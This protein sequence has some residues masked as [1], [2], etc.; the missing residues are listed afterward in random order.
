M[1][2]T[3]KEQKALIDFAN[4]FSIRHTQGWQNYTQNVSRPHAV[5]FD[6]ENEQQYQ[7]V[8]D[9]VAKLNTKKEPVERIT[10]RVANGG[11]EDLGEY[12]KYTGSFSITDCAAGDVIVRLSGK[13]FRKIELIDE[14]KKIVRVGA[15]VLAGELDETLYKKFSLTTP[16]SSYIYWSTF[17][18]GLTA[19]GGHGTG[20]NQPSIPGLIVSMKLIRPDGA[21]V[22]ISGTKKTIKLR[23]GTRISIDEKQKRII[24]PDGRDELTEVTVD[25]FKALQEEFETIRGAH[26]GLFGTVLEADIQC[27]NAK[28]LECIMKPTNLAG[29]KQLVSDG[30]YIKN[31]Y[32]TVW[33]IP[34]YRG[35]NKE[36]AP[37]CKSNLVVMTWNPVP[38]ETLDSNNH[39]QWTI[40]QEKIE[41]GLNDL[42]DLPGLLAS[43][44]HLIPIFM[45]YFS[46]QIEVRCKD[47]RVIAPWYEIA[48]RQIFPRNI[49]DGDILF[50]TKDANNGEEII[51]LFNYLVDTLQD[52]AD[53]GLYPVIYEIFLRYFLGSNG[54]LSMSFHGE[55]EH[56]A[57]I[58]FTS[59]RKI[60][61]LEQ[62]N[63]E[64]IKHLINEF[65]GRPHWGKSVP[66][67]IDYTKIYG[68]KFAIFMRVL[69]KWYEDCG[70]KLEESFLLNDFLAS[71]LKLETAKSLSLAE[72]V[73]ERP[74]RANNWEP[75]YQ[76]AEELLKRLKQKDENFDHNKHA[77]KFEQRLM[78]VIE[79]EKTRVTQNIQTLFTQPV[80]PPE[81]SPVERQKGRRCCVIV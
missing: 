27:I 66:L 44:P 35:K 2:L 51:A 18:S 1:P 20:G 37:D 72:Q 80:Q 31:E 76:T 55:N 68:D 73:N 79:R 28:K 67:D 11:R 7:A 69:K 6:V 45:R 23:G 12:S 65:G 21:K 64:V 19:N 42:F 74:M 16:T 14:A 53:R 9:F 49:S 77:K 29:F 40:L 78:A 25:E 57:G 39:K 59:A 63:E 32:V 34:T 54:G 58:D 8:Q 56:T 81:P 33:Y 30:L 46:S 41:I 13:A 15:G 70:M 71:I 62:F 10:F 75:L 24:H 5:V 36:K 48:H 3:K 50:N 38:V 17:I 4:K 61:G 26:L 47:M 43:Y 22:R 60:R 52:Y